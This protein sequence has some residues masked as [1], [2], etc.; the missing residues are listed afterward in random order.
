MSWK[1]IASYA[2]FGVYILIDIFPDYLQKALTWYR[3]R[4]QNQ[5]RKELKAIRQEAEK[6]DKAEPASL[7]NSSASRAVASSS[8]SYTISALVLA[9]WKQDDVDNHFR[10]NRVR[11]ADQP[12]WHV[13]V[14][15]SD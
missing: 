9:I 12:V 4:R 11:A 1:I 5:R 14:S 8:I 2:F 7:P 3:R 15:S 6:T 10:L 13:R